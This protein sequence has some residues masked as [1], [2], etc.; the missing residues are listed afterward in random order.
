MI[1]SLIYG[2]VMTDKQ[3]IDAGKVRIFVYGT[4]KKAHPNNLVMRN[5][6]AEFLGHDTITGRFIMY[7]LGGIP[8]VVPTDEDEFP[9]DLN[10]I[11]GEIWMGDEEMLAAC[12]MLEGH[13]NF[14]I[15]RKIWSDMLK[16]RVWVYFMDETWEHRACDIVPDG[17]WAPVEDERTFWN[18]YEA[19]VEEALHGG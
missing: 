3:E 9:D 14:Y 1:Q 11:K 19:G 5:A 18:N 13:P 10:Q 17:L 6:N 8:A 7:D 12:D 16:K 4:L 15:R 2:E